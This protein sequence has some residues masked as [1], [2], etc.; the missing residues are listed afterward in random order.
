MTQN[1]NSYTDYSKVLHNNGQSK[2]IN[3]SLMQATFEAGLVRLDSSI[4]RH[5]LR[6]YDESNIEQ[7]KFI[8]SSLGAVI[9]IL[10]W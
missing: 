6:V 9:K 7:Q 2:D 4:L 8:L 3:A 1:D 10:F 5:L